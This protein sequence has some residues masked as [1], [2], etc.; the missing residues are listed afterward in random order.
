MGAAAA[1]AGGWRAAGLQR[2][3]FELD[4][5]PPGEKPDGATLRLTAVAGRQGH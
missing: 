4:G 1:G 3:A 2:F 5:L